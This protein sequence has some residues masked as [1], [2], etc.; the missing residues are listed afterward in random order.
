MIA[1]LFAF[2]PFIP[3]SAMSGGLPFLAHILFGLF[4]NALYYQVVKKRIARGYHLVENFRPTSIPCG[5]SYGFFGFISF[6]A[7]EFL[8]RKHFQMTNQTNSDFEIAPENIGAYLNESR[9]K[10]IVSWIADIIICLG[11]ITPPVAV[12]KLISASPSVKN[13][14]KKIAHHSSLHKKGKHI[15]KYFEESYSEKTSSK[16]PPLSP[17]VRSIISS[18][19][20]DS[21]EVE[22]LNISGR[23]EPLPYSFGNLASLS[24]LN[25]SDCKLESLPESIGKLSKLTALNISDCK[26]SKLPDLIGNLTNLK[27]LGLSHNKLTEI[28]ESIENLSNLESLKLS[29]NW[30]RELPE[31]V[32]QLAKLE[33]LDLGNL[34]DSEKHGYPYNSLT[35]LSESIG[36]LSNLKRLDLSYNQL[37]ELPESLSRLKKL[38]E[39][40]LRGNPLREIPDSLKRSGLKIKF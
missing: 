30:L 11:L 13:F 22:A 40:D 20:D 23:K 36:N 10:H 35:K 32:Y 18:S 16:I 17:E 9:D 3:F 31:S 24:V 38:E 19:F 1:P 21:D 37:T 25:I 26:L 33:E 29:N 5:L 12:V 15:E 8:K 7:D 6:F 14:S 39:L 28:P 2:T 27:K 4:G 34:A